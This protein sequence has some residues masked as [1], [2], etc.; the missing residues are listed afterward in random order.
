MV[1]LRHQFAGARAGGKGVDK[2]Y[3]SSRGLRFVNVTQGGRQVAQGIESGI[4]RQRERESRTQ[5]RGQPGTWRVLLMFGVFGLGSLVVY[6]MTTEWSVLGVALIAA[7]AAFSAGALP[8]FLF[9][10]PRTLAAESP[11][12]S[13]K[14]S[15]S[16]AQNQLSHLPNTNL[17]QISD[18]LTKILV[19]VGLVQLGQIGSG[20]QELADGLAPGLGQHGKPVA[21]ALLVSFAIAGFLSAYLFTRLRLQSAFALADLVD[22]VVE[23]RTDEETSAS[24]LVSSQLDPG[25]DDGPGPGELAAALKTASTGTRARAFFEARDQR[26][27]SWRKGDRDEELVART[28]PVFEALIACDL[29]EQFH[30]NFGELGYALKDKA[31][32]EYERA[33]ANLT[34]AIEIRDRLYPAAHFPMYEFNR[35]FCNVK[36][37]EKHA[38]RLPDQAIEDICADLRATVKRAPR[39]DPVK[40]LIRHNE[41]IARWAKRYAEDE[42]VKGLASE[43]IVNL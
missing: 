33:A 17:E 7:V 6:A 5:D 32:P 12:P 3:L 22:R 27:R 40:A 25:S 26:R 41:T 24:A 36:L 30:R 15:G 35:A 38:T 42:C 2:Y 9:G 34:T 21:V 37:S 23:E 8:G 20:L 29:E 31:D 39:P 11:I 19:G 4:S 1:P 10:I 28:I 13:D 18:W 43:E 16:S 14:V